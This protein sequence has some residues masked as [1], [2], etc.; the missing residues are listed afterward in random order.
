[1][2]VQ[3][4]SAFDVGWRMTVHYLQVRRERDGELLFGPQ[5]SA[6]DP[7]LACMSGVAVAARMIAPGSGDVFLDVVGEDGAVTTVV[8]DYVKDL[9]RPTNAPIVLDP[10]ARAAVRPQ[11][12]TFFA[13]ED[14]GRGLVPL[15][16][17]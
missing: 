9:E 17:R 10:A 6:G 7:Q 5:L 1:M 2:I 16:S 8:I 3:S 13:F 11:H 15:P 4:R 12:L 14:L